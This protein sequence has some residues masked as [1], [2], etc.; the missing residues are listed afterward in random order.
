[1]VAIVTG[2]NGSGL[3][4]YQPLDYVAYH[5]LHPDR[6]TMGYCTQLLSPTPT[7]A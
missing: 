5:L 1:M 6:L 3:Q 7:L 4:L 2:S